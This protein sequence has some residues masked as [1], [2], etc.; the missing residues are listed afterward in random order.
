MPKTHEGLKNWV[1][2]KSREKNY[3]LLTD[4]AKDVENIIAGGPVPKHIKPIWPF[5]AFT[6]FQTL[7]PEFKDIYGIKDTKLKRLILKLNLIILKSTRPL[8]PPFFRLIPPA[9]WAKQR[10]R[11]KPNLKFSEKAKI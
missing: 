4:V 3:L 7:P 6:A 2:E 1:I 9:R 5:I 8:L 10:L 11:R